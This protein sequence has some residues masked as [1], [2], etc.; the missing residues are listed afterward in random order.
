MRSPRIRP[1]V[2]AGLLAALATNGSAQSVGELDARL[3]QL[4][5]QGEYGQAI[6]IARQAVELRKVRAKEQ[7][8][9]YAASLDKLAGLYK[10]MGA[11]EKAGPLFQQAIGIWARVKGN[12]HPSYATS[13]NNLAVLYQ[14]LGEFEKAEP[15]YQQAIEIRVK[16]LG[17]MHRDYA[18][19]LNNLAALYYSMGAF[20]KAEPLY[21]EA[22]E[23]WAV[24]EGVNPRDYAA[25]LN[26][27]AALYEALGAFEKAEPLYL[28]AQEIWARVLGK[29]HPDY[30]TSLNNLGMLY[31][32][33]DAHEKAEPLL[34]QAMEIRAAALGEDHPNYAASLNN[35]A[36]LYQA[37]GAVD[38]AELL[39]L[40]AMEIQAGALG[41][42]HP[43]YAASLQNLAYLYVAMGAADC[44][45]PLARE[46]TEIQRG[47]LARVF[48]SFPEKDREA[49]LRSLAIH[50]LPCALENGPLAAA[51]ALAFKGAVCASLLEERCLL[52]AAANPDA[53]ALVTDI[54]AL[55]RRFHR[56]TLE[57][58]KAEMERLWDQIETVEKQLA[59]FVTGLGAARRS[60]KTQTADVQEALPAHTALVEIMRYKRPVYEGK[61]KA[62]VE[63]RYGAVVIRHTGEP[64]FVRLALASEIDDSVE[65][66]R[67][68]VGAKTGAG[69]DAACQA[70]AR[71]LYQLLLAPLEAA[72]GDAATLV[73]SPD[74]QLH[75]LSFEPLLD[76]AG[77][78]ACEKWQIR[79]IDTGRDLLEQPGPAG[80]RKHALLLGDPAFGG[81][82]LANG[83]VAHNRG[84]FVAE[85]MWFPPLP[86][87]RA[88][89]AEVK[90]ILE[91]S[92]WETQTLVG[93]E[94]GESVLRNRIHGQGLVH[95]A[96]HGFFF[97][98]LAEGREGALAAGHPGVQ[99]RPAK[100]A[101]GPMD[102][103][104]LALA[105][106]NRTL[107]ARQKGEIREPSDDGML[108]AA[109]VVVLDLA[110]TQLVVLSACET[111]K[112]KALDGEG[113]YGLRRALKLAGADTVVMTLWPVSDAYTAGFMQD[114]YRR[115]L[116][117][118]RHPAVALAETKKEHLQKLKQASG[119]R[120]A[121][122]LVCP[123]IATGRGVAAVE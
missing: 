113:I 83:K 89:V 63:Q 53:E 69:D 7:P 91:N 44:A 60:L 64:V 110:G 117:A 74:S 46:L 31:Q 3:E 41:K 25:S 6:P 19:S 112:G 34:L 26:N 47:L 114:F 58:N 62:G 98:Q 104:G 99:E 11:Y 102:R 23:I 75:F 84:I 115:Y 73:L 57:G 107:L 65:R 52:Q 56:A 70:V 119:F 121:V 103:S 123:F 86:G 20:E 61:K 72:L 76:A 24:V 18:T 80:D 36:M 106:A 49:Y 116:A 12:E 30:A 1:V 14:E 50:G 59:H 111:A 5:K 55:R 122:Q 13:L 32:A 95:L 17:K 15:L 120:R 66:F 96:T 87:T 22:K 40:R 77:K 108:T 28:Q 27:L 90:Q 43:D 16:V 68:L 78:M 81:E 97:N 2:I 45:V 109:E 35:L 71:E 10:A 42:D 118:G 93:E 67:G 79:M 29:E 8:T 105:G 101:Q 37:M 9:E 94:A 85:G 100:P 4:C 21:L 54:E 39:L 38:K 48:G 82:A 33:M 92:H 88:E 51:S